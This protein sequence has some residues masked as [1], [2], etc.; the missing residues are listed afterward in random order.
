MTRF[1]R[2]MY[3]KLLNKCHSSKKAHK[4]ARYY[5]EAIMLLRPKAKVYVIYNSDEEEG[6]LR[7]FFGCELGEEEIKKLFREVTLRF[8]RQHIEASR[9]ECCRPLEVLKARE[10]ELRLELNE[11]VIV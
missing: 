9:E 4:L 1:K 8:Y 11:N 3:F 2:K 7:C 6:F 10:L 5:T